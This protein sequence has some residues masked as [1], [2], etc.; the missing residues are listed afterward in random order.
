MILRVLINLLENAAKFTPAQGKIRVTAQTQNGM[1]LTSIKD[2][3]PGIAPGDQERIFEKYTQ[4]TVLD[5]GRGLGLGLAY[6]RLAV[7]GH[8]GRIWVE[9]EQGKGAVFRFSLP[10]AGNA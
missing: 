1:V 7:N 4:L 8:G 10:A 6:C 9:S 5:D 3:G 2:N